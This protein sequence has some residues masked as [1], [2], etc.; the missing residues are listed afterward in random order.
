[1]KLTSCEYIVESILNLI[2]FDDYYDITCAI[3]LF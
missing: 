3:A 2:L 1:M